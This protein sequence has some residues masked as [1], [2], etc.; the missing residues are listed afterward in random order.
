MVLQITQ[1]K[2]CKLLTSKIMTKLVFSQDY[3]NKVSTNAR[4]EPKLVIDALEAPL[5]P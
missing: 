2:Q 3:T 1:T 4:M 5:V